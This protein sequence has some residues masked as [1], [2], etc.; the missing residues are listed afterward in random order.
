MKQRE[1]ATSFRRDGGPSTDRHCNQHVQHRFASIANIMT[2]PAYSATGTA[3]NCGLLPSFAESI[4]RRF[5]ASSFALV[6]LLACMPTLHAT[7]SP[8]TLRDQ[9]VAI[10]QTWVDAIPT[11]RKDIWARTLAD[12]AVLVDEFG[13]IQ[14]KRE[15][16][17][18]LSPFP[19][20]ISGSIELRHPQVHSFGDTAILE[21]EQYEREAFFGQHFVVRYQTLI[22]FVKQDSQWLIAGYEDVT[23]PTSPPRLQVA[24]LQTQDY[25]GSYRFAPDHAWTFSVRNHL[26][27]YVTGPGRPFKAVA[28]VA[29]DVFM[30]TDD[31]RNLLIFRRNAAGHVTELIE[32]RKFNDLHL[33]R[34]AG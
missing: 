32:R 33:R 28:P 27:G 5:I 13:G 18:S 23:I 14:H 25:V 4:M 17:A 19:A 21:V 26:L 30:G 34:D 10:T 29:H 22:T 16:V 31:E 6:T 9:L 11:G 24:G 1:P 15:A 20:E 3:E 12:D 7:T 2:L 8:R